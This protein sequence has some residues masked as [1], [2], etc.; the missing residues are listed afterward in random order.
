MCVRAAVC[1]VKASAGQVRIWKNTLLRMATAGGAALYE[2]AQVAWNAHTDAIDWRAA[3]A[4]L[5]GGLL[6]VIVIGVGAN[7]FECVFG[8]AVRTS[9]SVQSC[10][11]I[12]ISPPEHKLPMLR[13]QGRMVQRGRGKQVRATPAQWNAMR[14]ALGPKVPDE[15]LAKMLVK[16]GNDTAAACRDYYGPEYGGY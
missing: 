6:A 5:A 8:C 4:L 13:E 15:S 10:I 14:A 9:C 16:H 2:K 12:N 1:G 7:L 11:T 3:L